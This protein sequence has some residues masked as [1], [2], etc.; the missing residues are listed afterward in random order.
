MRYSPSLDMLA[1]LCAS[2][3]K[4]PVQQYTLISLMPA[5]GLSRTAAFEHCV[6]GLLASS[7]AVL[8]ATVV[9]YSGG[10]HQ[11]S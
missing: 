7:I 2:K 8:D 3:S 5:W 6:E 10:G 9:C 11:H 1:D 4:A